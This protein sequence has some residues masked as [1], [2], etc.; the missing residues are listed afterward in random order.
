[1][2]VHLDAS[3]LVHAVS[4]VG[5]RALLD[6]ASERGDRLLISTVVLYEWL[7]GPRTAAELAFTDAFFP[8]HEHVVFGSPEARTAAELYRRLNAARRRQA[9]IAIAACAIENGASIW[10]LNPGDFND[11]P[12]LTLYAG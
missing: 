12:G 4:S 1:V 9:D 7:R 2:N 10:T 5:R 6:A 3:L 11:I 8:V